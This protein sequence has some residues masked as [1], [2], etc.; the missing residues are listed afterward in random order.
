V[1][2]EE[3]VVDGDVEAAPVGGKEAVQARATDT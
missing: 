1:L 3:A 2:S